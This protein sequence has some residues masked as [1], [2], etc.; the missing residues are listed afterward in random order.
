[1]DR[2][3]SLRT[4]DCSRH[5]SNYACL[6]IAKRHVNLDRLEQQL[7]AIL[8]LFLTSCLFEGDVYCFSWGPGDTFKKKHIKNS[9]HS[10]Q[11]GQEDLI[12]FARI[13]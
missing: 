6:L 13:N 2:K 7:R 3:T 8:E 10:I 4:A 12:I 1:M 9:L 11:S 5:K